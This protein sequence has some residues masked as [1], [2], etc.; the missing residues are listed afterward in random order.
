[1]I[2]ECSVLEAND[3]ESESGREN[4]ESTDRNR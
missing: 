2:H 3:N 1:M 4:T